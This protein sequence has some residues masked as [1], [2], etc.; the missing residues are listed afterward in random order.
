M[1]WLFIEVYPKSVMETIFSDLHV[2]GHAGRDFMRMVA[3]ALYTIQWEH[4]QIAINKRIAFIL[5]K[6]VVKMQL[7]TAV[8]T[9][10]LIHQPV[11]SSSVK[12][13]HSSVW[14]SS[15]AYLALGVA[16]VLSEGGVWIGTH[17]DTQPSP[18]T[19]IHIDNLEFQLELPTLHKDAE[20]SR[21]SELS[22]TQIDFQCKL[23]FISTVCDQNK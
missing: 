20:M 22:W 15:T 14:F 18:I 9:N 3:Y 16:E 12:F 2:S 5:G 17:R 23:A 13:I 8:L 11:L 7:L 10:P 6:T 4:M 21:I 19:S 1:R